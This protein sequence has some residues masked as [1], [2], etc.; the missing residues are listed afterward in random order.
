MQPIQG[1]KD[2]GPR[3]GLVE[4]K[5]GKASHTL[6]LPWI[7]SQLIEKVCHERGAGG[8]RFQRDTVLWTLSNHLNNQVS[9]L[10]S[11]RVTR[12][13]DQGSIGPELRVGGVREAGL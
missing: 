1:P 4:I 8:I 7:D 10:F 11:H 6:E 13:G 5:H 12:F 9:A 3:H 2:H